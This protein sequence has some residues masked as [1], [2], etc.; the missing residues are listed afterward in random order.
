LNAYITKLKHILP[1]FVTV[2]L[3]T[4]VSLALIRWFFC[5]HFSI[6]DIKEEVWTLWI[7][8][9]FPWIPITL[10]L[11]Q[12][13][14]IIT[15][16]ESD[17]GRFAF[18][19]ISWLVMAGI[20]CISQNY[21]TTATGKM[22]TL[23]SIKE[24][25]KVEKVRYYK[26]SHFSVNRN[27]GGIHTVIKTSGKFNKHLNFSIFFVT[28]IVAKNSDS[29]P[30]YWYGVKYR[31]Q[32]SN[33]ISRKEKEKRYQV[34]YED[35]IEKMN[36]YNFHSLDHFERKPTSNDRDNYLKAI[37]SRTKQL[38]DD[39]FVVLEPVNEKFEDR[40]GNTLTWF[41]GA[42]AIGVFVLL[43]ALIWPGLSETE[44]E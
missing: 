3:G 14:R 6:I 32:I 5:L 44:Q 25:D 33:K 41:F 29:I 16:K 23:S 18:Q 7:P 8:L 30:K 40:N 35:C 43:F 22:Q 42:F 21:L 20:L 28:P 36:H 37:R 24:M 38:T 13:F 19:I 9:I 31:Q 17:R 10:W 34:F 26:L 39:T 2:T 4:V 12:R 11:R 27:W 1:T 15:F